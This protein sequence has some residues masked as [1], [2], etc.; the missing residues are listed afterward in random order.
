[1][2]LLLFCF[3]ITL[4]FKHAGKW[5]NSFYSYH[6]L[7]SGSFL[8]VSLIFCVFDVYKWQDRCRK[9]YLFQ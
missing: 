1:L 6:L 3:L 7:I 5:T 2:S 4:V 8:L 9:Q